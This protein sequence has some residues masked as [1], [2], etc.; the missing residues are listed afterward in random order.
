[1]NNYTIRMISKGSLTYLNVQILP[2]LNSQVAGPRDIY[3][4]IGEM[5][6]MLKE[7]S[8]DGVNIFGRGPEKNTIRWLEK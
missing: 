5:L 3:E 4:L 8:T 7:S 6:L 2:D 1:M